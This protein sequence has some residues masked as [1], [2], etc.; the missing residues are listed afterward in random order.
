MRAIIYS[1]VSTDEQATKGVSLDAQRERL[2]AYCRALFGAA[3]FA[4]LSDE[5]VSGKRLDNRPALQKALGMLAAGEADALV[6]VKLDR[7]SRST[8]DVLDL[9]ER[10]QREGWE[11]HSI[12]ETLNTSTAMGRF[13]LTLLG[14]LAQ[15]EREQIAERTEAALSHLRA[16][17]KK[18]GGDVPFGWRLVD[19]G[20][21]ER[22]PEEFAAV[23]EMLQLQKLGKSGRAIAEVLNARGVTAKRGGQWSSTQVLRAVRNAVRFVDSGEAEEDTQEIRAL[24]EAAKAAP[25]RR[26]PRKSKRVLVEA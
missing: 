19:G 6:V 18:T 13:A 5:G 3:P 10:C 16:S 17:G 21:V 9:A 25:K 1:R 15:L 24:V 26:A 23:L 8:R 4:V 12:S 11:L 22:D 20:R 7:L 14:S 2:D